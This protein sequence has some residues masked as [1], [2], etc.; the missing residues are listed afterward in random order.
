MKEYL[1]KN[2]HG[3]YKVTDH[4]SGFNVDDLIEVPNGACIARFYPKDPVGLEFENSSRQW[5]DDE[6]LE[7]VDYSSIEYFNSNK[8]SRI[9]WQ[10]PTHPEPL[11]FID[12][13]PQ[14]LNDQCAEIE[15]VRQNQKTIDR[16]SV[17]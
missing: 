6:K 12:D 10:R 1:V 15:Q 5:W 17:V 9:V 11:P 14:S 2:I 7:W 13:N 3:E 16:K 4:H 8:F